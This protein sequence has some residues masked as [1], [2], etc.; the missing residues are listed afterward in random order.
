MVTL[1]QMIK[2]DEGEKLELYLDTEGYQTIGVGHLCVMSS[3]RE[4]AVAHL[5]KILGRTTH[6]RIT[7]QES[8]L[9]FN[10]D[11]QKSLR[12]IERTGLMDIYTASNEARR[13]ALVNLMFNLGGPR[14]LGFRNA[15]KA[16]RL[17]DYNKAAN[18]F[19]DS[20]WARQVKSRSVRVTECIRNG[21]MRSYS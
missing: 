8:T 11:V 12:E 17:K 4:K 6:G 1:Y 18:E 21:D 13:A 7:Q 3:S 19:L 16:W 15:L 9:L 14:L 5:D 2:R 20:R 10:Q